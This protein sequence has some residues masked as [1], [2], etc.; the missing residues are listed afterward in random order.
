MNM[1][2]IVKMVILIAIITCI[3]SIGG[4][5]AATNYAISANKISYSDNSN[6][7]VD[8]VQAAIDGT[9]SRAATVL[10]SKLNKTLIE[11][12]L[13]TPTKSTTS[14]DYILTYNID[15]S[16]YTEIV[17]IIYVSN[18]WAYSANS[19]EIPPT[20]TGNF[21]NR[22]YSYNGNYSYY[23]EGGISIT[24]KSI[25]VSTSLKSSNISQNYFEII[26]LY[27]R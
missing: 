21:Y 10:D 22:L 5:Y 13:P 4:A 11:L 12:A 2:K 1:N 27:A 14:N 23:W 16:G 6:L 8:N 20:S 19:Y 25:I 17:P 7:G 24:Q 18:F 9:C 3:I 15:L 26:K